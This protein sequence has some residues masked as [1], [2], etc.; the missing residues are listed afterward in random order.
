MQHLTG[1]GSLPMCG[2]CRQSQ[3]ASFSQ[4]EAA[5][6]S[7]EQHVRGLRDATKG[8]R[9]LRSGGGGGLVGVR[10][11]KVKKSKSQK[12]FITPITG[13]VQTTRY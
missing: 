4:L 6:E 7:A 2:T 11:S 10:A 9:L 1:C 5:V 13:G 8:S 3:L 12:Y